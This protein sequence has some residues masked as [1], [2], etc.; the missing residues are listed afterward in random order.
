MKAVALIRRRIVLAEDAF[1]EM[2]VWRVPQP[3]AP[4]EHGFRYRL[5]YVVAGQST[6]RYDN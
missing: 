3:V 5:V 1:V 4:S 2:V 6:V